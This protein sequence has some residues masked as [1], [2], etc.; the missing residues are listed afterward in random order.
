MNKTRNLIIIS[1][2]SILLAQGINP[3]IW[4]PVEEDNRFIQQVWG[5]VCNGTGILNTDGDHC[6]INWQQHQLEIDID[7]DGDMDMITQ[8]YADWHSGFQGI[9]I[10]KN[11][12][13]LDSNNV[14]ILDSVYQQ[15]GSHGGISAGYFNDDEFIDIYVSTANYHGPDWMEPDLDCLQQ[16]FFYLG[17]SSGFIQDT[18][19][20]SLPLEDSMFV[21]GAVQD[22]FDINNDGLDEILVSGTIPDEHQPIMILSFNDEIQNFEITDIIYSEIENGGFKEWR[23]ADLNGDGWKDLVTAV[24]Y[25]ETP[26]SPVFN[27]FHY[28]EG[29]SDGID[30]NNPIS[31]ASLMDPYGVLQLAGTEEAITPIDYDQD[32]DSE[33]LIWWAYSFDDEHATIPIDSIPKGELRLYDF[34]IDTLIDI[35]QDAFFLGDNKDFNSP[36]NGVFIKDLNNDGVD[37]ILF[38]TTWCLEKVNISGVDPGSPGSMGD[39]E[40]ASFALNLDGKFHLY[41]VEPTGAGPEE[42]TIQQ[43]SIEL[44]NYENDTFI[45]LDFYDQTYD[46]SAGNDLSDP[47]WF[48]EDWP[49]QIWHYSNQ[50][51]KIMLNS[52]IDSTN[53]DTIQTLAW[54]SDI[55]ADIYRV[56]LSL[57]NFGEDVVLDTLITDTLII[58]DSLL[59]ESNYSVRV[60]GENEAGQGLWSDTLNFTTIFL[61]SDKEKGFLPKK[62]AL[63]QNFPNPFNPITTLRYDLPEDAQV[64]IMIYDLMGRE[65]KTLVNNQQTAGFK[66]ILWDATN[67]LGQPVSAGMYLYRISAGDFHSVK[68]MILLK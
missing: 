51:E 59:P 58:I 36:G 6:G 2:S 15:C 62:F 56:Q 8:V 13:N 67:N 35:T 1:L 21:F 31:I 25:R 7:N 18:L 30:I 23:Y 19:S 39:N 55:V 53:A 46:C 48:P 37:D 64:K 42:Q 9:G 16:D 22:V 28:F 66:S 45:Y 61:E 10:F 50:V 27:A 38:S 44:D 20:N 60:R 14:F 26:E 12:N 17:S 24:P 3:L 65:V 54:V 4:T 43:F 47:D 34:Q 68:K 41:E 49:A 33:L 63:H 5:Q 57:D 32:G 29:S 52:N 11:I 40:C